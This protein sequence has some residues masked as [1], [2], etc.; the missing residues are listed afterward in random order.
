MI[1][2]AHS[3]RR[4][5]AI[6]AVVLGI[7]AVAPITT[8]L[9]AGAAPD[10]ALGAVNVHASA[11]GLRMPFYSHQGE[12][13]EAE[14]PYALSDLGGGGVAHA[15][16]SLFWPGPTGATLGSTIG[17]LSKGQ[18]PAILTNNL[19]DPF[20]A[21]APTTQGDTK[22]SMSQP[23][24]TMQALALPDHVNASSALG[25][26]QLTTNGAGPLVT[27]TTNIAFKGSSIVV[28]D[29][30][31]AVTDIGIGPLHLGSV[32]S[33]AHATSD[34]KHATGTTSTQI[35]GATIAGV[36]VTIDQNGVEVANQGALPASIVKTLDDTVNTALKTAGIRIFV[37]KAS[38]LVSGAQVSLDAGDLM[39]MLHRPGY[40]ANFN[41][42]GL[43]FELGGASITANAVGGYVAPVVATTNPTSA[44]STSS[45]SVP[46]IQP[47]P[48]G[49]NVAAPGP[50]PT[51]APPAIA[52][53]ALSLPG[54]LSSWWVIGG[55][56]LAL[57]AGAALWL[58][59]G[60]A[61]AAAGAGCRLEE[62][63]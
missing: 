16:T 4:R 51:V 63:L 58:L 10:A 38:K 54:A 19:N 2:P 55:I 32:V 25:L 41:D 42:T 22:V 3:F 48:P 52:T 33:S 47:P 57:L 35:T 9:E 24:L 56:L 15:L 30:K 12:D 8:T 29:A 5:L 61:L 20:K 28:A 18:A 6:G 23:G 36:G 17:V 31:S 53:S 50:V 1:R 27:A 14:V 34:G 13:A 49:G 39:V 37:T 45:N 21:E 60:R 26:S 62:E 11:V 59:P 43:F 46:P 7:A 40:H 44:P